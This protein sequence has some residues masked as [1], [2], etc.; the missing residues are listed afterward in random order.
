MESVQLAA[1]SRTNTGKGVARSLRREGRVPAVIY[2]H[3]REPQALAVDHAAINRLLDVIGGETVLLDV[4]VDGAAPVKAIVREVQRNPVRRSDVIHLDLYAVVADEPIV[5]DVP[6]HIVGTADGVRN[7]GGVLDHHLHRLSIR[8]LP[9]DIPEHIEVDVTALQVG[10]AIHV[11]DLKLERA[12][13][14][15]DDDVSIVTVLA[16]R[17]DDSTETAAPAEGEPEV[18]K[19]GKAEDEAGAADGD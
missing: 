13:L 12:E 14:Q 18:I 11:G 8:C 5:V 15:L 19:K 9:A 3:G 10:Q 1:T 2:G 6:V 16:A 17:I 7:Q 4:S